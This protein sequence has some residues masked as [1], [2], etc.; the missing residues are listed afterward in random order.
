MQMASKKLTLRQCT[1]Q[2]FQ[3]E[4]ASSVFKGLMQPVIGAIPM[5]SM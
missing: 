1:Q 5:T 4:G 3:K 2:A